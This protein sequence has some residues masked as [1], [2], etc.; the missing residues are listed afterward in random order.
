M[1]ILTLWLNLGVS[2]QYHITQFG[3]L[4]V[5][6]CSIPRKGT[7]GEI[8]FCPVHALGCYLEQEMVI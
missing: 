7:C 5:W 2:A 4:I 3:N 8:F 1:T 6:P